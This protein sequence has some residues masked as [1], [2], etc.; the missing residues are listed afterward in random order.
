[1]DRNRQRSSTHTH[2]H[3]SAKFGTRR[4]MSGRRM[5]NLSVVWTEVGS[6]FAKFGTEVGPLATEIGQLLPG[7]G[8]NGSVLNGRGPNFDKLGPPSIMCP[9]SGR[10]ILRSARSQ[11]QADCRPRG[12]RFCHPWVTSPDPQNRRIRVCSNA[13]NTDFGGERN[14]AKTKHSRITTM[15]MKKI[16]EQCASHGI[17]NNW[18][19][20]AP[21]KVK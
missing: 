20:S 18:H 2:T 19:A 14:S 17:R 21:R 11:C 16:D 3:K 1:M 4:P 7:I 9:T 13:R 12:H 5:P 6:V 15:N 10:S 8:R